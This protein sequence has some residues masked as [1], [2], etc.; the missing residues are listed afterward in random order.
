MLKSDALAH[1]RHNQSALARAIGATRQTVNNW[2]AVVPYESAR[3]LEIATRG[4]LRID[5]ACYPRLVAVRTL[6]SADAGA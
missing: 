3:A 1:F 2:P 5:E 6:A 4:V